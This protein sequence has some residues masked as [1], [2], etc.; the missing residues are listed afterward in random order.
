M[1]IGE[2]SRRTGLAASAIRYYEEV[3]LLPPPARRGGQRV[4]D[5]HYVPRLVAIQFAKEAGFSLA[6][7][8]QLVR[9][10]QGERWKALAQ[11]K[12]GEV[13]EAAARLGMMRTLLLGIIEC[14]C[15][16]LEECGRQIQARGA[17]AS[18]NRPPRPPRRR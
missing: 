11:R 1:N 7:I 4:F 5:E 3:G 14:G 15:F 17:I 13:E 2:L 12:L 10:F 16:D 18:A 8:Q 6:E 9:R